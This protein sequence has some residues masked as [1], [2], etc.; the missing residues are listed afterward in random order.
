MSMSVEAALISRKSAS[1]S[2][3]TDGINAAGK[4]WPR[5]VVHGDGIQAA[6]NF[7]DKPYFVLSSA[8]E[9]GTA[10]SAADLFRSCVTEFNANGSNYEEL[11][12]DFLH[13]FASALNDSGMKSSDCD[14]SIFAASDDKAFVAKSGTSKVFI[15]SDDICREATVPMQTH[16]DNASS[17]GVLCYPNVRA[18]DIFILLTKT[19]ADLLPAEMIESICEKAAG[20]I[21]KAVKL[22]SSLAKKNGCED[23]IS[24]IVIKVTDVKKPLTDFDSETDEFSGGNKQHTAVFNLGDQAAITPLAGAVK[25]NSN[26]DDYPDEED[27]YYDDDDYDDDPYQVMEGPDNRRRVGLIAAIAVLAILILVVAFFAIKMFSERG[28]L[29]PTVPAQT[30]GESTTGET[31]TGETTTGETTTGETTT[32]ETTT[33]E[34]TTNRRDRITTE[35]S[36]ERVTSAP[37]PTQPPAPVTQPPAP[38]TDPPAPVTEPPAPVTDPPAPVTDPPAPVTD[39]PA[40]VTDPPA[41][42]TDPP[43][44]ENPTIPV[45]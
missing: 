28:G 12:S 45:F 1:L 44:V 33:G 41:P 35:P 4:I 42:V 18:G 11:I 30:T 3:N 23:A 36:Q 38:V 6:G 26:E 16:E 7:Q 20:D 9:K 22:I 43:P 21:K 25:M 29:N 24:A 37:R 27:D 34:T 40:P 5:E 15:Y 2:F 39:P 19:M 17:Y 14:F 8:K 13:S 32:G 31:T 10:E